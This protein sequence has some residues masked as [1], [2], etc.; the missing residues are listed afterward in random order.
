MTFRMNEMRDEDPGRCFVGQRAFSSDDRQYFFGRTDESVAL[1]QLLAENAVV[2]LHG[3]AGCGKSSLLRAGLPAQLEDADLM[4]PPGRVADGSFFPEA[5]LAGHNPHTLAVL[6]GWSPGDSRARLA[7]LSLTEFLTRTTMA[8]RQPAMGA[9]RTIAVID[10]VEKIFSDAATANQRSAF[11]AD[12]IMA[13]RATPRLRII[14][15]VRSDDLDAV[16]TN[17]DDLG[18][19]AVAVFSLAPLSRMASLKA[20]REPAKLAGFQ[21]ADGTAE[22][23]VDS[24]IADT[25]V[26]PVQLQVVGSAVLHSLLPGA[27]TI[28]LDVPAVTDVV[29]RALAQFCV[30]ALAETATE[31]DVD[32]AGLGL[33]LEQACIT[34]AG[35][36]AA[37]TADRAAV[38]Q[39]TSILAG[40]TRRHLLT[41]ERRSGGARWYLLASD[42]LVDLLQQVDMPSLMDARPTTEAATHLRIAADMLGRQEL[43]LAERHARYALHGSRNEDL[44]LRFEAQSLL[45]NI[46]FRNGHLGEAKDCYWRAAELSEQ[47]Q[48]EVGVGRLLG[49]I[50]QLHAQQGCLAAALEDLQS[51]VA[52]VPSDLALQTDLANVLWRS[53][54]ARAAASVFGTVL[55]VEPE[56]AE[57]LAGRGQISAE[58]G[59]ASLALDDLQALRR[60]RPSMGQQPELR[61]AYA[62]ALARAG[63]TDTAMEEANAAV[64]SAQD[65]GQILLQAARVARASGARDR[66][67]ALLQL[68]ARASNPKVSV[69]ELDEARR[70]L[71]SASWPESSSSSAR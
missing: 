51:A 33:W 27:R 34:P 8:G 20:L 53:G 41:S 22:L 9:G 29:T 44:R 32:P 45:G 63:R 52:R 24:L 3:P 68:A 7:T 35:K 6:A 62:L 11:F 14:L 30:E 38:R 17:L 12:L 66:A 48:D 36:R 28:R 16:W 19:G 23:I 58:D 71:S 67:S 4:L 59:N 70:L 21:F 31:Q 50:G 10:Q 5:A 57:A 56:F 18:A 39:A 43:G 42:P 25:Y 46:A 54:Q 1:R 55:T 64:A 47:L 60:L 40:L 37:V 69:K 61:S 65:N 26:Q 2:I 13:L 49:A 15:S